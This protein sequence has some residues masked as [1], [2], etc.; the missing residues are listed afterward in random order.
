MIYSKVSSQASIGPDQLGPWE[1]AENNRLIVP[2]F[3]SLALRAPL[4]EAD[5]VAV[6]VAV[7]KAN[8]GPLIDRLAEAAED[9]E[10]RAG[11]EIHRFAEL[12]AAQDVTLAGGIGQDKA[13][14]PAE[15]IDGQYVDAGD[16]WQVLFRLFLESSPGADPAGNL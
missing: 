10:A 8:V 11:V 12:L 7:G 3:F 13:D 5:A 4:A 2:T 15:L 16:A 6:A 9:L 1:G 14:R